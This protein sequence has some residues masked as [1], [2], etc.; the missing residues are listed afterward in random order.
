MSDKLVAVVVSSLCGA[1]NGYLL[2]EILTSLFSLNSKKN[3]EPSMNSQELAQKADR[4]R[5][6]IHGVAKLLVL[7]SFVLSVGFFGR[8]MIVFAMLFVF[9]LSFALTL[10]FFARRNTNLFRDNK[11]I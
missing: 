11:K 8:G 3:E 4:T 5:L 10:L 6:A 2:V 9:A 1:V 7:I